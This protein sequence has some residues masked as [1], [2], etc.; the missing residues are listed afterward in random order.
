MWNKKTKKLVADGK[1]VVLGVVQ[2]QHAERARLYKQWKQ[3]EFPIVQDSFTSLGLKVVPVPILI[4]EYGYVQNSRPNLNQIEDLVAV[5]TDAAKPTEKYDSDEK[6][7]KMVRELPGDCFNSE[8][9]LAQAAGCVVAT[10]EILHATQIQS[11]TAKCEFAKLAIKN[12]LGALSHY[13]L[14]KNTPKEDLGAI[15]FRLG[16]AYRMVYDNATDEDRDPADF[17]TAAMYWSKALDL[18]PNQ[19]IWRRR[20]EQYGPRQIKPYPFYDWVEQAQKEIAARGETPVRLTAPLTGAEIAKPS[21]RFAASSVPTNPTNPDPDAKIDLDEKGLVEVHST[22][23]PA[24]ITLGE[25]VRVHVQ[26]VPKLGKWNNESSETTVWLNGS[27]SGKSTRT[28][29]LIPNPKEAA[30]SETR[31]LEFEFATFKDAQPDSDGEIELAGFVLFNACETEGGQCL[32]RRKEFSVSI[33]L[34]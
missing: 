22:V 21:R 18:N 25:T 10:D 32:Y 17:K 27:S 23:V 1:L 30:S 12:Y 2:E 29:I 15:C 19:Y 13:Q 7:A 6:L 8:V 28:L 14:D 33:P 24:S 9:T 5:K 3:Y 34:K 20:I 4:D 31:V 26:L 11:E 16:V